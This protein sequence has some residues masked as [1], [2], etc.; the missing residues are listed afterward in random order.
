MPLDETVGLVLDSGLDADT[1][2]GSWPSAVIESS[3]CVL[4]DCSVPD[5]E[6]NTTSP[7]YWLAPGT[8]A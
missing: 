6:L 1:T 2:S 8:C 3:S 4:F 5:C 7:E